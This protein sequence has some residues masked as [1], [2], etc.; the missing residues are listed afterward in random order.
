MHRRRAA[1]AA[2]AIGV[3][4]TAGVVLGI[5][6]LRDRGASTPFPPPDATAPLSP[7]P[8]GLPQTLALGM[9]SAPGDADEMVATAPF[10]YR[11]QYLAGGVQDGWQTWSPAGS[12]VSTYIEESERA[13]MVPVFSYYMLLQSTPATGSERTRD[14][15]G[16]RDRRLMAAY[17]AD[18]RAFFQR[19]SAAGPGPV[20]LQVEPDLWGFMHQLAAGDDSRSVRAAVASTGLPELAGYPDT[21]AGLAQ[22]IVALRDAYAPNVLLGYQLSTWG[23]GEDF[24]YDRPG[25][26]AV[27]SAAARAAAFYTSLGAK[28]DLVFAE[29]SDRDAGSRQAGRRDG[30]GPW[31]SEADF[32]RHVRFLAG[33]TSRTGERVV[34]WQIPYGNTRFR[35]VDNSRGHYQDNRVE[36]L[37]DDPTGS[38][39]RAYADAGVIALF[40]GRGADGGTDASDAQQDGVTNP[41]PIGGNARVSLSADDDGG[42]FRERAAAFYRASPVTFPGPGR[43][44]SV[45]KR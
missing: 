10:G 3:L 40:F 42:Y 8:A 6:G 17:F 43:S 39:L 7:V 37:L 44:V 35:A 26:G 38:H 2:A 20:I 18:L 24:V 11:Y 13:G 36:W 22:A 31:W 34:L 12:F 28:F 5:V 29:F 23:T 21:V 32:T 15:N 33:F 1:L 45:N 9:A 19:A 4:V 30:S 25:D 16:L 27:D 14:A 41:E